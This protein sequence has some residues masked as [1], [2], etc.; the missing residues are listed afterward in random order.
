MK[1]QS[2]QLQ[3]FRCFE[4]IQ[5][6]FDPQLTVFTG[7]NGSGKTAVLE[8]IAVFT[9]AF[10]EKQHRPKSVFPAMNLKRTDVCAWRNHDEIQ[11]SLKLIGDETFSFVFGKDRN[12]PEQ[13]SIINPKNEFHAFLDRRW[14]NTDAQ[15]TEIFTFYSAQR[16][17]PGNYKQV[18]SS[19]NDRDNVF[20]DAFSANINFRA[21]SEWFIRKSADQAIQAAKLKDF[22]HTIPEVEAVK[23]AVLGALNDEYDDI[24]VEVTTSQIKLRKKNTQNDYE[25]NQLSDGYKTMLA[26]VMD[27]ARRMAVANGELYL[28]QEKSPLESPAIVL[29]DEVELHLHPSWQQTVLPSLM[30][31]FPNTQF[32]VTTHSPQVIS[33]IEPKHIRILK[34]GKV[35]PVETSTYG[36][37]SARVLEEVFGVPV[38]GAAEVKEILDEYLK[39]INDGEGQSS[40]AKELRSKLD[41]WL[42][43]DPILDKADM[44]I[45]RNARRKEREEKS[46]AQA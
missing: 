22:S 2:L 19:G 14:S 39:L 41:N 16:C 21:S 25:I 27:L 11:V 34:A 42:F 6:E 31:I 26:L 15:G 28:K 23:N 13:L 33:S 43:D 44:F 18:F 8:A 4:N 40:N 30:R 17:L 7:V 10:M 12:N 38:R 35:L 29:I 46:H 1:I 37:E 3:G 45:V 24:Q 9:K 36:A 5:V 20:E 32:V